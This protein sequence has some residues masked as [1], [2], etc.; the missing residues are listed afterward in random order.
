MVSRT[1]AWKIQ[2]HTQESSFLSLQTEVR[3]YDVFP[4]MY[5]TKF[6]LNKTY[7]IKFAKIIWL[8]IGRKIVYCNTN[9]MCKLQGLLSEPYS[10]NKSVPVAT[11]KAYVN[12]EV[13][14]LAFIALKPERLI[15]LLHVQTL[16][17][18]EEILGTH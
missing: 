13:Q 4:K 15:G 12:L 17:P 16:Y 5:E 3:Q 1:V 18:V 2:Q 8:T 7:N 14:L 6:I 11:M 9:K 10:V